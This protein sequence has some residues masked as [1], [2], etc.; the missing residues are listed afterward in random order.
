MTAIRDVVPVD[1]RSS[2]RPSAAPAAAMNIGQE[3][4]EQQQRSAV[5]GCVDWFIYPVVEDE[6]VGRV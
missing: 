4:L 1:Y 6:L 5:Y 2:M 3:D